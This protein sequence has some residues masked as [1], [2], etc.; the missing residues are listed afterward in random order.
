VRLEDGNT[1]IS[2][3]LINNTGDR[4]AFELPKPTLPWWSRLD[5][6]NSDALEHEFEGT[7]VETEG[8]SVQLLTA[9]VA[10]DAHP[11]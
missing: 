5:T 4:H 11:P 2:L 3:L 6:A 9:L 1:E 7:N 10:A 8:H